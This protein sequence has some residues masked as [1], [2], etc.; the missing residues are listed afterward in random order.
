MNTIKE[1]LAEWNTRY[2][3]RAKLQHAYVVASVFGIIVAGLIGLLN[4]DTSR[5]ILRVCFM[6][7]GIF[8]VNAIA[9]ALLYGLVIDRLPRRANRK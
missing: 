9:W 2:S 3:E 4:Y 5:A 8:L 1:M 6:G 7:L